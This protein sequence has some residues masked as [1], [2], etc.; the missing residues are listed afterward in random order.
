MSNGMGPYKKQ[1]RQYLFDKQNGF[2]Y[3]CQ[4]KMTWTRRP[5]GQP[6]R[7][8]PTLEHLVRAEDGGK[9][10][11]TNIVLVH[12]TCNNGREIFRQ[13]GN[14][15]NKPRGITPER[16]KAIVEFWNKGG[17]AERLKAASC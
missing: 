6:G 4:K 13:S 9:V 15:K 17:V 2:C 14:G 5:S 3:Y 8:F 7:L 1:F 10:N 12:R 11:Y 16:W